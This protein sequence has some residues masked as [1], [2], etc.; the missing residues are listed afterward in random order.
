[1]PVSRLVSRQNI[2]PHKHIQQP[3]RYPQGPDR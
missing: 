3:P 1:L 2:P